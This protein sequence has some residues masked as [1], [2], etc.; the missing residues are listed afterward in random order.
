M[1]LESRRRAKKLAHE[2][3]ARGEPMAWFEPFYAAAGA[4][5]AAI[6]W[7][8]QKP[9]PKLVDWLNR[10]T[11]TLKP[12]ARALVVGCGLGDD[13]MEL[14]RHGYRVTAFDLSPTAIAWCH[15]RYPN[16]AV[17]GVEFLTADLYQPPPA[18][19]AGFD[20]VFEACT[21][22][23][24]PAAIRPTGAAQI[25]SFVAPGGRLLLICR[26]REPADD[27]GSLP[28]PLIRAEIDP[29]PG[30]TITAFEDFMDDETPPQRRFRVE[31]RRT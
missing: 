28:W 4:D 16:A 31:Y 27:P 2:A 21:L 3:I 23:A 19:Q 5:A 20:L 12:G 18:W 24:L 26:G 25:A 13:A 17:A 14:A 15:R 8:D 9:N 10:P 22:Q 7:A 29:L 11:S 1:T 30:L 6:P